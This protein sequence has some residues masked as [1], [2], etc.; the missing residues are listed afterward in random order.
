MNF[1]RHIKDSITASAG[2]TTSKTDSKIVPSEGTSTSHVPVSVYESSDSQPLFQRL[3]LKFGSED[4]HRRIISEHMIKARGKADLD[5]ID[6]YWFDD[7]AQ[8]TLCDKLLSTI[9]MRYAKSAR[10]GTSAS[11]GLKC[12]EIQSKITDE[13]VELLCASTFPVDQETMEN[14]TVT[15]KR[16]G[17][18]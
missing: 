12:L 11:S 7:P 10:G 13:H 15:Y 14:V 6:H 4:H 16:P 2:D 18:R 8:S 5:G 9:Q 1:I 3:G 17:E